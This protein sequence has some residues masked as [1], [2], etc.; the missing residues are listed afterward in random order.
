MVQAF[1]RSR[2]KVPFEKPSAQPDRHLGEQLGSICAFDCG[3]NAAVCST[4]CKGQN[5][6][7]V[8]ESRPRQRIVDSIRLSKGIRHDKSWIKPSA[9][10]E[11]TAPERSFTAAS[12]VNKMRIRPDDSWIKRMAHMNSR[13]PLHVSSKGLGDISRAFIPS[14]VSTQAS[15]C[16]CD[17]ALRVRQDCL[18]DKN[19]ASPSEASGGR[20]AVGVFPERGVSDSRCCVNSNRRNCV[21]VVDEGCEES[22][23]ECEVS[24]ATFLKDAVSVVTKDAKDAKLDKS[25]CYRSPTPNGYATYAGGRLTN[26]LTS[27]EAG[28][29]QRAF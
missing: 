11:S 25:P 12:T 22:R 7:D 26:E 2:A 14:D 1:H 24:K 16:T 29:E 20:V 4:K 28:N 21:E 27:S 15:D 3:S 13:A 19:A 18:Y 23:L 10:S 9:H 6:Y 8:G 17:R 5:T